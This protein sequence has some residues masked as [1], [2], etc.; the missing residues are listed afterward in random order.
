MGVCQ[1]SGQ[2][3]TCTSADT[4]LQN[5]PAYI[6]DINVA[7]VPRKIDDLITHAT[8]TIDRDS[9]EGKWRL[10]N[11]RQCQMLRWIWSQKHP[12]K[13]INMLRN[14]GL[15]DTD[16]QLCLL[17]AKPF[18]FFSLE[19]YT[20]CKTD[21]MRVAARI[22]KRTGVTGIRFVQQG[23]SITGYSSNPLKGERYVPTHLYHA[24]SNTDFRLTCE[25][26]EKVIEQVIADGGKVDQHEG[27]PI[28]Y[29]HS[30]Q[31]VFP[32]LEDISRK[33]KSRLRGEANHIQFTIVIDSKYQGFPPNLWD[34]PIR[35]H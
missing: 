33:W 24:G 12:S 1:S 14:A 25:G 7:S 6:L 5:Q 10:A 30:A 28:L 20:E 21:L 9:R 11:V 31:V 3:K 13:W 23:S 34:L 18:D 32:E 16:I 19:D 15:E 22:E 35:W 8:I 17:R 29:P 4:L 2:V 27:F 26:I